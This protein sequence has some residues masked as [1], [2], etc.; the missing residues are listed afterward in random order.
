MPTVPTTLGS[1]FVDSQGSADKPVALLWPSLFT[2]HRMWRSQVAALQEDGWR[3]LA[4]DPPGH[5]K[6]PGPGRSF[7]MDECAD[8]V[9]QVL[10]AMDVRRP[11]VLL[12]TSWGGF[13]APRVALRAPSRVR[14][15]VLFNTSA[16]EAAP[17]E[18]LRAWL[19]TKLLAVGALDEL[20]NRVLVSTMLGK[21]TRH[22][23]PE[24]GADLTKDFRA[25]DRRGAITTVRSV[26]VERASMLEA[27]WEVKVPA[28]IVSA[29]E[30]TLLPTIHS[31]RIVQKLANAS[32]VEVTGAKH[33]VPLEVPEAANSL[34]REFL[35]H[36]PQSG[37]G[38]GELTRGA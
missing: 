15:M 23:Q 12:G 18:R 17:L 16:E 10:D 19:L 28:L 3:T 33:L 2:D 5:G 27:L 13:V 30:D 22:R 37:L 25:W 6:S 35:R 20:V 36:L 31:Q 32:H 26:L 7:T 8:A 9:V 1:L 11:V 24:V 14:G 21:E 29:K 38:L 34:I 4:L